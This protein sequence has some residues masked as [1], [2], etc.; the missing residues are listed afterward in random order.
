MKHLKPTTKRMPLRAE[1]VRLSN[2]FENIMDM[3]NSLVCRVAPNK[4]KCATS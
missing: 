2:P 3:I 1:Q 4:E